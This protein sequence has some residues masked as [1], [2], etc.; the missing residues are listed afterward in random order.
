MRWNVYTRTMGYVLA[1][2]KLLAEDGSLD[3]R[4]RSIAMVH[5]DLVDFEELSKDEQE[6]D[7]LKLTPE[8]VAILKSI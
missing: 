7:A 1:D 2:P 3:N 6:K 4:T 5:N 8:I